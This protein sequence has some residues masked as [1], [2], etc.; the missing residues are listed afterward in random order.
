MATRTG[1]GIE[2]PD[3]AGLMRNQ[4]AGKL[5]GTDKELGIARWK[6]GQEYLAPC[7]GK[8]WTEWWIASRPL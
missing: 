8:C 1:Y 5:H 4:R 6:P 2:G 7:F 3:S